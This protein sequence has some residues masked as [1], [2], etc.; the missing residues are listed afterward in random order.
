MPLR[1]PLAECIRDA[2]AQFVDGFADCSELLASLKQ[3]DLLRDEAAKG[4]VG[5]TDLRVWQAFQTVLSRWSF[6]ET[7]DRIGAE[8]GHSTRQA[9]RD[10]ASFAE[11]FN[12][13]HWA[14]YREMAREYRLRLA[15]ILLAVPSLSLADVARHSGYSCVATLQ[16][17]LRE[18]GLPPA[19]DVRV[20]LLQQ[21]HRLA[22]RETQFE[23]AYGESGDLVS[24]E[25]RV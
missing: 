12:I 9:R 15:V 24:R 1:L 16:R 23:C 17:A 4:P 8:M 10:F 22:R 13:G 14:G 21:K 2:A 3:A 20:E 18:A 11:R 19:A 7:L 6:G 25:E 5:R